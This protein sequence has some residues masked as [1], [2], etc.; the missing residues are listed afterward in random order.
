MNSYLPR[1]RTDKQVTDELEAGGCY[2]TLAE[3]AMM[4]SEADAWIF[5]NETVVED[6]EPV[7]FVNYDKFKDWL[8]NNKKYRDEEF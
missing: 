2:I 5:T 3:F 6:G 1:L 4:V 8:E 7:S